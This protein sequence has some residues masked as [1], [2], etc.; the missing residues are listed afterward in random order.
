MPTDHALHS[1]ADAA[2]RTV[3]L[4]VKATVAVL[5][6][7]PQIAQGAADALK[8]KGLLTDE[9]TTGLHIRHHIKGSSGRTHSG[10]YIRKNLFG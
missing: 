9:T 1:L 10:F 6:V 7:G 3:E 4:G 2:G 8:S 5:R